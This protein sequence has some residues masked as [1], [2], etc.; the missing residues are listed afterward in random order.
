MRHIAISILC[1]ITLMVVL[2]FVFGPMGGFALLIV[3]A[4]VIGHQFALLRVIHPS[5]RTG[6]RSRYEEYI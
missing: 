3:T 4:G 1:A 2:S 6:V 5:V